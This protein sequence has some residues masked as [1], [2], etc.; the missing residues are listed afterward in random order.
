MRQWQILDVM[1]ARIQRNK[2]TVSK[3]ETAFLFYSAMFRR[4]ISLVENYI[5]MVFYVP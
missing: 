4:N 1:I 3:I 5:I 2:K